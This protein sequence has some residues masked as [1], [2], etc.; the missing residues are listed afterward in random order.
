MTLPT[1]D[2]VVLYPSGATTAEARVVH[3]EAV[4][5][6]EGT[7][8][9]VV[10]DRTACHPVDAGWPDQGPDRAVLDAGDVALERR[11]RGRAGRQP[12]CDRGRSATATTSTTARLPPTSQFRLAIR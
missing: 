4:E 3:V 6:P 5:L 2:T 9:A 10:L 8:L 11:W 1:S 7:R 12:E